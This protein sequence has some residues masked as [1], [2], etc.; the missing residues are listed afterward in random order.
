MRHT[1]V[2][3]ADGAAQTPAVQISSPLQAFPSP[4]DVPSGWLAQ[5]GGSVV[6]DVD[7]ELLLDV[8]VLLDVELELLVL[9]LC[10][11][12]VELLVLVLVDDEVELLVLVDDEVELLVDDDVEL[13]VLVLLEVDVVLL[14]LVLVVLLVL[15]VVGGSQ[16]SPKPSRSASS[17][18]GLKIAGQLSMPSGM[19]SASASGTTARAWML[20]AS[21]PAPPGPPP[22]NHRSTVPAGELPKLPT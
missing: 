20:L 15:V 21:R 12:D 13:L 19:P 14:V 11:V 16:T 3:A 2:A 22:S 6:L 9:V 10:E 5:N 18:P 17:W 8:L 4:H 1:C 7:V